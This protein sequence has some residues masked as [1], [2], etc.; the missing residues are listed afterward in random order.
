MHTGCVWSTVRA[1]IFHHRFSLKHGILNYWRIFLKS[2]SLGTG[3]SWKEKEGIKN[4]LQVYNSRWENEDEAAKQV[5][6]HLQSKEL[7]PIWKW[8]TV[9]LQDN[10]PTGCWICGPLV[11]LPHDRR[12]VRGL[13]ENSVKDPKDNLWVWSILRRNIG[14]RKHLTT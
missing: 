1:V 8:P 5:L 13:G 4:E 12:N 14:E 11:Q 10:S 6:G 7:L 2:P 3:L 9:H